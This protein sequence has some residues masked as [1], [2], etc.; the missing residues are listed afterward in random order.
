LRHSASR[1]FSK[2]R[3]RTDATKTSARV[4]RSPT[5]KV[6]VLSAF[7]RYS[8]C[9]TALALAA[10]TA[11]FWYGAAPVRGR[12]QAASEGRRSALAHEAQRSASAASSFEAPRRP[13]LL[14]WARYE[15][16]ASASVSL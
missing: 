4:T 11:G 7:S 15:A 9:L 12:N 13:D 6:R 8:R 2:P 5:R 10:S 16:M 1:T 14:S 3:K